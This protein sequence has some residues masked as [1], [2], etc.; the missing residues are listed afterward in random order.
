M[1]TLLSSLWK[2]RILFEIIAHDVRVYLDLKTKDEV[3]NSDIEYVSDKRTVQSVLSLSKSK[4]QM[5][6]RTT[7]K[8][9]TVH[10]SEV[11]ARSR[12][13]H[14]F[15]PNL[16]F[17]S[18]HLQMKSLLFM[19]CLWI[20]RKDGRREGQRYATSKCLYLSRVEVQRF[21]FPQKMPS[22]KITDLSDR[23]FELLHFALMSFHAIGVAY[24][25]SSRATG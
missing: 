8:Y 9:L 22:R 19:N 10:S 24:Y 4:L 13:P 18:Q 14:S 12:R 25:Y 2:G 21:C 1:S 15:T 17:R 3:K 5:Q 16:F 20:D 6:K 11:L 23:T 7:T